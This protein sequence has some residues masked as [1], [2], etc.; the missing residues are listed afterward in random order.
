MARSYGSNMW[1]VCGGAPKRESFSERERERVRRREHM[2]RG[3][4]ET[5]CSTIAGMCFLCF[6]DGLMFWKTQGT[7]VVT[8]AELL[9][10]FFLVVLKSTVW[11]R[12]MKTVAFSDFTRRRPVKELK[13]LSEPDLI[14]H[15][16]CQIGSFR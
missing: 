13:T 6:I 1:S 10:V 8:F 2:E 5:S 9:C 3:K 7:T 12:S 4:S 14:A 11:R 16:Y 15:F